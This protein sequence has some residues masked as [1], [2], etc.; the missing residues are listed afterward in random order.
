MLRGVG[1]GVGVTDKRGF[2]RSTEITAA[3]TAEEPIRREPSVAARADQL[4][5]LP[6]LLTELDALTVFEQTLGTLHGASL[7]AYGVVK[8]C[9][10]KDLQ[11]E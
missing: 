7:K 5:F 11:G 4:Q 3:L 9:E 2:V 10:K 1:L 8:Q 6:A